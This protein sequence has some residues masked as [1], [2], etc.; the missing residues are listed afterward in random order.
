MGGP[1]RFGLVTLVVMTCVMSGCAAV[2]HGTYSS[3][4]DSEQKVQRKAEH[5][6]AGVRPD[7]LD[8]ED[9]KLTVKPHNWTTSMNIWGPFLP[10]L[11]LPVGKNDS[12]YFS[13]RM[14][15]PSFLIT[16]WMEPKDRELSFDPFAVMPTASRSTP[17]HETLSASYTHCNRHR[18]SSQPKA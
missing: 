1:S 4:D 3:V 7:I 2:S 13:Q 14:H 15:Q 18:P 10:I 5:Y 8:F 17:P 11:P 6:W 12:L 16:L 9:L